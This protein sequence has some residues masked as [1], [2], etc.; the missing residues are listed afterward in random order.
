MANRGGQPG[1]NNGGKAQK[2]R[3]ALHYAIAQDDSRKLK[4]AAMKL[5]DM[6]VEGEEWAIKEL[7]D[8]LDGKPG[9]AVQVS[10]DNENP[11]VSE[12][13]LRLVDGTGGNT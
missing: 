12:L 6:A 10:G 5:L 9:Q 1:N 13:L 3:E 2:W 11:L 7:G 4:A 8:R